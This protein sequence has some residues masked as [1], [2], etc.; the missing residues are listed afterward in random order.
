MVL[1]GGAVAPGPA[2]NHQVIDRDVAA[3]QPG[4]VMKKQGKHAR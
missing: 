4:I 3:R 1:D 2:G